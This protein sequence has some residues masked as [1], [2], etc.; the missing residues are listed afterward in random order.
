MIR[1]LFFTYQPELLQ[2]CNTEYGKW[3]LQ[4]AFGGVI[5]K[6][7]Q[8]IRVAPDGYHVLKDFLG[9][10]AIVQATFFPRSPYIKKFANILTGLEILYRNKQFVP[11]YLQWNEFGF[12]N[13]WFDDFNP[14]ANPETTSVD[15]VASRVGVAETWAT[16]RA[17]AG[18][19]AND[20]GTGAGSNFTLI[21]KTTGSNWVDFVRGICLFDTSSLPDNATISSAS[22]SF[23]VAS[24]ELTIN[25][26]IRIVTTTPASDTAIVASDYAN[27]GTVAQ[28]NDIGIS[29]LAISSY[30]PFTFNA[31]GLGNISKTGVSKFGARIDSDADNS[32]PAA[33]AGQACAMEISLAD[34]GSNKP[35]LTVNYSV[36]NASFL[37]LL[38]ET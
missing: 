20:S 17:G 36:E 31:T 5:E 2:F 16:I 25:Q 29:S 32:E 21:R 35:K 9:K 18:N 27:F 6:R 30:N 26:S 1:E 13:L 14:D 23:F 24:S 37:T 22:L 10:R 15:G 33:S 4:G 28:A 8:I 12:K 11:P 19:T 7:D 3:F 38:F 34:A